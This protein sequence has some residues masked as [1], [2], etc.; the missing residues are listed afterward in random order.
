MKLTVQLY[1][2]HLI[3]LLYNLKEELLVAGTLAAL[4]FTIG[5]SLMPH[6][7][8]Y[9]IPSERKFESS[10]ARCDE[11]FYASGTCDPLS[12][13]GKACPHSVV[14]IAGV[15]SFT[16]ISLPGVY[17]GRDVCQY[18]DEDGL[19]GDFEE[20]LRYCYHLAPL[21][22]VPSAVDWCREA[23]Y[24]DSQ[25][26]GFQL[27]QLEVT[28]DW[29]TCTLWKDGACFN[30]ASPGFEDGLWPVN[31]AYFPAEVQRTRSFSGMIYF[32]WQN[33]LG[34]GQ[35]FYLASLLL[36]MSCMVCAAAIVS[37]VQMYANKYSYGTLQFLQ[38]VVKRKKGWVWRGFFYLATFTCFM[39]FVV[40]VYLYFKELASPTLLLAPCLAMVN[41]VDLQRFNRDLHPD[42][43][44]STIPVYLELP[45][46]F[47]VMTSE[48]LLEMVENGVL[49]HYFAQNDEPFR[50]IFKNVDG[51]LVEHIMDIYTRFGVGMKPKKGSY[52]PCL[53]IMPLGLLA[54]VLNGIVQSKAYIAV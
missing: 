4:P 48:Q 30:D 39:N 49:A 42:D 15:P 31:G 45:G 33:K 44:S 11:A 7:S 36:S 35:Y 21:P 13:E 18:F 34:L 23:C 32:L 29:L 47:F 19:T 22:G 6:V 40:I 8:R 27:S 2:L 1:I 51:Q 10:N 12:I 24:S 52:L 50:Q 41:I 25:C 26:Q 53:A 5:T 38:E 17:Q 16:M 46:Y 20:A 43:L 14:P 54:K 28:S 37:I 3:F 9:L